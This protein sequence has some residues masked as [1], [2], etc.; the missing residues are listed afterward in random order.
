M[1]TSLGKAMNKTAGHFGSF[2]FVLILAMQWNKCYNSQ[3]SFLGYKEKI[4][5]RFY[6]IFF[7]D[8]GL[9]NKFMNYA[10]KLRLES[11]WHMFGVIFHSSWEKEYKFSI[12]EFHWVYQPHTLA[13]PQRT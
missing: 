8:C 3:L 1:N 9:P 7:F 6:P 4:K 10:S 11:W 13:G 2:Y 12:I 5:L